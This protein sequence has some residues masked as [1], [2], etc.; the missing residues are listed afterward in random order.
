[1]VTLQSN[2]ASHSKIGSM[3]GG[4]P[5]SAGEGSVRSFAA[6][7]RYSRYSLRGGDAS[8]RPFQCGLGT[9]HMA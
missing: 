1:M 9:V 4:K 2:C 3:S 6:A 7:A 8:V 5:S